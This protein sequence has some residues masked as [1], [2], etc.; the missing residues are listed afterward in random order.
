VVEL[1]EGGIQ[2]WG[3]AQDNHSATPATQMNGTEELTKKIARLSQRVT[4]LTRAL[5]LF[6]V[7]F[8]LS[9]VGVMNWYYRDQSLVN[10]IHEWYAQRLR[11]WDNR[12]QLD[13]T[14]NWE[15]GV[16][17]LGKEKMLELRAHTDA[18][19]NKADSL[20]ISLRQRERRDKYL[21]SVGDEILNRI[22]RHID[23]SASDKGVNE[24][25]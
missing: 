19:N 7:I 25:D 1:L 22:K 20:S 6:V 10:E 4:W 16:Q 18:M 3:N 12:N 24:H 9:G 8:M 15:I 11:G 2:G 23:T 14:M 21:D 17:Y 5:V 13:S